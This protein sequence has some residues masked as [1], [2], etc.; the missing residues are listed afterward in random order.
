MS[1]SQ[2]SAEGS[3]HTHENVYLNIYVCVSIGVCLYHFYTFKYRY[4]ER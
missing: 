2:K 1:D 4:L 3:L